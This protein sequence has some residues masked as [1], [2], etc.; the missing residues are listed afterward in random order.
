ME[1]MT[2]WILM[3]A[4]ALALP[5]ALL[6]CSSDA[7]SASSPTAGGVASTPASEGAAATPTPTPTAEEPNVSRASLDEYLMAVC[8]DQVKLTDWEEGAS[9]RKFSSDLEQ[10]LETIESLE[11]PLE[12]S[13]W[14]IATLAYGRALKETIDDHIEDSTGLAKDE[15]LLLMLPDLAPHIQPFDQAIAALDPDVLSRMSEAGC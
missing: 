9:L 12:V 2:R 11:P 3:L 14:H 8:G 5:L 15:L 1:R 6:A 13:D 10:H 7:P 4:V